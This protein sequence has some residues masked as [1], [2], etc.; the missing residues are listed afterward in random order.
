MTTAQLKKEPCMRSDTSQLKIGMHFRL[1][2][3][4]TKK[5]AQWYRCVG[6][7]SGGCVTGAVI[8]SGAKSYFTQNFPILR[9]ISE[10]PHLN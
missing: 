6:I 3:T 10:N 4:A 9:L 8:S 1:A 7:S 5:R 2:P